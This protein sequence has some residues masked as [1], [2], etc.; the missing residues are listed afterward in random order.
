VRSPPSESDTLR[1][2][3]PLLEGTLDASDHDLLRAFAYRVSEHVTRSAFD[4]LKFVFPSSTI[5]SWKSILSRV[6]F[7]SGIKPVLYDSCPNS[8]ILYTA[9]NSDLDEC[10]HCHTTRYTGPGK[11]RAQWPY[12]PITPRLKS[13]VADPRMASLMSYRKDHVHEPGRTQDIFDGQEYRRLKATR[14]EIN[15]EK[16]SHNHFSDDRDI[17]LGLACDGFSLFKRRSKKSAW[18]LIALNYNLPPDIRTHREHIIPLGIIPKKPVDIDSWVWPFVE[19]LV[20]FELGVVAYDALS[21]DHFRLHTYLVLIFG[22]IPAISMLMQ[23]KGHNGISPCRMCEIKAVPTLGTKHPT[24]YVP[25]DRSRHPNVRADPTLVDRYD[26][27]AL[28]LR[29]HQRYMEQAREVQLA[30]TEAASNRLAKSYGIKGVSVFSCLSSISFPSSFPYGFMH[31]VW[32]NLIPN[33]ID[34]WTGKFKGLDEGQEDY[35][36]SSKVWEAVGEACA[37]SKATVPAA[38][39]PAPFNVAQD[40]EFWTAESRAFWTQFLG[41]VTLENRFRKVKYYKHFV[42]LVRILNLCLKFEYSDNDIESIRIGL[43]D[44]VNKYEK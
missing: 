40:Q 33:L 9:H 43:I 30:P 15:G 27:A 1:A 35:A 5:P 22:D 7:L 3:Y 10:P 18:P 44:W 21:N 4:K 39:G 37:G 8:C 20:R 31:L 14:V 17:A 11:A 26:P 19:E 25:L 32:M 16:L 42:E 23:M 2:D 12:I 6:V 29:T 28:P 34:H 36:L 13:F 41:P 24:Y 38:C